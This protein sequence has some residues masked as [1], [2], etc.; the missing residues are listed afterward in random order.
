MNSTQLDIKSFANFCEDC[1][2]PTLTTS[3]SLV[4]DPGVGEALGGVGGDEGEV[5]R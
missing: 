1:V 4:R 5:L 2:S 3:L